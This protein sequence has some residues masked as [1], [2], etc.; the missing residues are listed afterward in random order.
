MERSQSYQSPIVDGDGPGEE[1][2]SR[3]EDMRIEL[4]QLPLRRST[5]RNITVVTLSTRPLKS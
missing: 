1:D 3:S 5:I 2:G 4:V